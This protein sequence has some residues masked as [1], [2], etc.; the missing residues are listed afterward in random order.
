MKCSDITPD[1]GD[2]VAAF[3]VER[4]DEIDVAGA[5]LLQHLRLLA[6]LRAGELVDHHRALAQ[7]AEL[8]GEDVA[9]DAVAGGVRLVIA[10]AEMPLAR[11]KGWRGKQRHSQEQSRGA[12]REPEGMSRHG[13]LPDPAHSQG[14]CVGRL[15]ERLCATRERVLARAAKRAKREGTG[16]PAPAL[17][18]TT[19]RRGVS[20]PAGDRISSLEHRAVGAAGGRSRPLL[21]RRRTIDRRRFESAL[22]PHAPILGRSAIRANERTSEKQGG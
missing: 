17:K 7:L 14:L 21:D 9:G 15:W 19:P 20:K 10:E 11:R 16:L 2:T 3:A 13:A 4:D 5:D 8:G 6:E 22:M 12:S 18:R 1:C